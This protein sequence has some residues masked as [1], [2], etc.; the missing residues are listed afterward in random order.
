MNPPN[1]HLPH[2]NPNHHPIYQ[3]GDLYLNSNVQPAEMRS[4]QGCFEEES[5]RPQGNQ[6]VNSGCADHCHPGTAKNHS[7]NVPT[8][9]SCLQSHYMAT[10]PHFHEE[11]HSM[12]PSPTLAQLFPTDSTVQ[13]EPQQPL[14]LSGLS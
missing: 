8:R 10:P 7:F 14:N 6:H 4:R 9:N 3:S 2:Q 5:L 12:P 11:I 13:N 1:W